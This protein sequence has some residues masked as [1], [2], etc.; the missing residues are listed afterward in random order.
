MPPVTPRPI[1]IV[2]SPL[3]AGSSRPFRASL[4]SSRGAPS[5]RAPAPSACSRAATAWPAHPRLRQTRTCS[6]SF[7]SCT[8]DKRSDDAFNDRRHPAG[9]RAFGEHDGPQPIDAAVQR[10]VHDHVV[11]LGHRADLVSRR[12]EAAA[13][14][15]FGVLAAPAQALLEYVERRGE[16]KDPDGAIGAALAHLPR[17]L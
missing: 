1:S 17:A 10:V 5:S 2:L 7:L 12:D 13:N 14:R 8:V 6:H 3:R 11:V 16:D 15:V 4:P 9:P